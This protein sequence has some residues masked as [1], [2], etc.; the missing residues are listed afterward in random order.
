MMVEAKTINGDGNDMD[1]ESLLHAC[2]DR[3]DTIELI[4]QRDLGN[5]MCRIKR[6]CNRYVR[7]VFVIACV[8]P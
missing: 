6:E 8:L 4:L 3:G 2:V 5:N 7:E 1:P